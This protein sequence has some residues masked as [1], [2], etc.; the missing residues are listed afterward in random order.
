MT[1]IK[2]CFF[3]TLLLS[4]IV[5]NCF[6]QN[7]IKQDEEVK[8]SSRKLLK[9]AKNALKHGDL[10]S[11]IDYYKLYDDIN[12]GK[13]VIQHELG[14]LLFREK[15]YNEAKLYLNNSYKSEPE[16][17]ILDLYT[18]AICLQILEEC[19][20]AKKSFEQFIKES[21]SNNDL[22][23]YAKLAKLHISII[24][25]LPTIKDSA[26]NVIINLL[27]TSI[28]KP[29][30]EFSPI[31]YNDGKLIYGSLFENKIKYYEIHK[32]ELPVRKFYLAKREGNSWKNLGEFD[33]IINGN[34]INTGNGAFSA[35]KERFYFSR[36]GKD[37]LYDRFLCKI[38]VSELINNEWQIPVELP[39]N[40]NIDNTTNTMP[41]LGISGAKTDVLYY[42][43]DRDGGRGGLDLWYSVYDRKKK[44]WKD[45]KNCGKKINTA[46][47]EITPYYNIDIKTLFYSSN[48]LPSIGGFDIFK[49]F[50]DGKNF[51]EPENIGYPINSSYDDLYYILEDSREKGFF[52]S[53]RAGGYSLRHENCC[54][55]I[56]EFIY[57]DFINIVVTGKIFGITDSTFFYSIKKNYEKEMTLNIDVL[58]D[59]D[60]IELLYDYPVNLYVIDQH[61]GKER[62]V[63]TDNTNTGSYIF[64]LEQGFD[65]IVEVKDFNDE[66][67]RI[68]F[69]TKHIITSDTLILDAILVTIFPKQSIVVQNI[70]YDFFES[71]LTDTAKSVIDKTIYNVLKK[72]P[73]IIIEVSSHTDARGDDLL[74]DKLSQARAQSVVDYLILKGVDRD[75]LVARGYGKHYPIAPNINSDGTDNPEG[76]QKNRRTEFKIIGQLDDIDEVIYDE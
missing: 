2:N 24:D 59:S 32:E 44:E 46:F 17:Y 52:T 34:N 6:S 12:P 7:E 22:K 27:D 1:D 48:G 51:E 61:S 40:I 23:E 73:N 11:A 66:V 21:K 72:Y 37:L 64:N 10:F 19:N 14:Q 56:Y 8:Y 30:I 3:I 62:F 49:S 74:N 75:R 36:C 15:N 42:V 31:P 13:P 53:N 39:S 20:E 26:L 43:S 63:K 28:N 71:Y 58:D 25:R 54:D 16:R 45:P 38:F 50:G 47:D 29:H 57:K 18:Y 41:T 35:D 33:T 4:I 67:R 60:D 65:Y 55:D 5:C 68:N 9:N 70:Y 69:T 76:R